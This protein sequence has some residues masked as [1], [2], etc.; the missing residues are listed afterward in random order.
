MSKLLFIL[1]IEKRFD[2]VI[3][4]ITE[5]TNAN[6]TRYK[7]TPEYKGKN[8]STTVYSD[9]TIGNVKKMKK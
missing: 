5:I 8:Y 6:G 2:A 1:D 4:E 3:V 7:F 9:G